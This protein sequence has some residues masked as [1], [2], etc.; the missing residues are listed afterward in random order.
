MTTEQR[1][2]A[3]DVSAATVHQALVARGRVM[4][5]E[6][7]ARRA[8]D[9]RDADAHDAQAVPGRKLEE[10][11]PIR[12]VDKCGEFSRIRLRRG[13]FEQDRPLVLNRA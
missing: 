12:C 8:G 9:D 5:V 1:A 4:R 7:H 3:H 13:A 10:P 6:D 11:R 2:T